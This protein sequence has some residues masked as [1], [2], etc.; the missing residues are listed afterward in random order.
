MRTNKCTLRAYVHRGRMWK[1]K[2]QTSVV[3]L[4]SASD[5][6]ITKFSKLLSRN[7]MD[8]SIVFLFVQ[9]LFV[10]SIVIRS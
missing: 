3:S 10:R 1:V 4:C 7:T 2:S 5:L 9:N 8:F 6:L